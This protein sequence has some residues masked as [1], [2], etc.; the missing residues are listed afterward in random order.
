M[1]DVKKLA[2]LYF[3]GNAAGI[4]PIVLFRIARIFIDMPLVQMREVFTIA[5]QMVDLP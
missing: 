5:S 4:N 1:T 2:K 3:I